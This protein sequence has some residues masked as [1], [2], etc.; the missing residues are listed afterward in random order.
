VQHADLAF[1]AEPRS[2]E[3]GGGGPLVRAAGR[4]PGLVLEPTDPGELAAN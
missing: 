4:A 2:Q 3:L 1:A